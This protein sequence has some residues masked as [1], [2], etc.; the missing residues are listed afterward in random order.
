MR[1]KLG[2]QTREADDSGAGPRVARTHAAQSMRLHADVP[3]AVRCRRRRRRR[4][5]RAAVGIARSHPA[6]IPRV[7]GPVARASRPRTAGRRASAPSRC[8]VSIPPSFRAI[9]AS[10]RSSRAAI[11]R[12]DF[13]PFEEMLQ[14]LARPYEDQQRFEAY[15]SRAAARRAGAA[16]FLRNL[17]R[18]DR[19]GAMI[20]LDSRATISSHTAV[21]GPRRGARAAAACRC[22]PRS[23]R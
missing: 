4:R 19:H 22:P 2:L 17:N 20:G 11:E 5:R 16:D 14:V 21:A 15:A 6:E 23:M 7:G 3:P 12:D 13:A 10:S 1:A 9:I 8:G 18:G